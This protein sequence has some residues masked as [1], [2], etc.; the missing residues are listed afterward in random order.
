MAGTFDGFSDLGWQR[1]ADPLPPE[2][3]KWGR[4][5][6]P[7]ALRNV[8]KSLRDVLIT[9]CCWCDLPRGQARPAAGAR[10]GTR[11]DAVAIR[12]GGGRLG[13]LAQATVRGSPMAVTAK[14]SSSIAS[15]RGPAGHGPRARRR[16]RGT[17][18]RK[19]GRCSILCPCA[20]AH[21]AGPVTASRCWRWRRGMTP[22]TCVV[23]SAA[24]GSG[25]RCPTGWGSAAPRGG[26]RSHRTG[27]AIQSS[28]RV[29]GSSAS[30]AAWSCAGNGSPP[31]STRVLPWP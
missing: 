22:K 14:V 9:G 6:P 16:P 7:T 27:L 31:A 11:D 17:S 13:P 28:G 2:P 24:V 12:R 29:P 20:L 1:F 18:G 5:M 10:R 15:R 3:T 23:A 25:P 19:S 26:G 30:T 4:G 21:A 8:V